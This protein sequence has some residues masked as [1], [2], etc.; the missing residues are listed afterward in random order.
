MTGRSSHFHS[1]DWIN[2]E[3]RGNCSNIEL[4]RTQSRVRRRQ[5]T[6]HCDSKLVGAIHE[7]LADCCDSIAAHFVQQMRRPPPHLDTVV[8]HFV[9]TGDM[10]TAA[11]VTIVAVATVADAGAWMQYCRTA[12]GRSLWGSSAA[13]RTVHAAKMAIDLSRQYSVAPIQISSYFVDLH[14]PYQHWWAYS[15]DVLGSAKRR[16]FKCNRLVEFLMVEY[17][18][19]LPKEPHCSSC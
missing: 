11:T 8:H 7:R 16:V 9:H 2:C 18:E 12:V 5:R 4:D 10:V 3:R 17:S 15:E 1:R 13:V 19:H 14:R 6:H